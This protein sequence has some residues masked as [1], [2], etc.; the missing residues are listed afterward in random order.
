MSTPGYKYEW[1]DVSL[2][3]VLRHFAKDFKFKDG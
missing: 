3:D 2:D 1:T